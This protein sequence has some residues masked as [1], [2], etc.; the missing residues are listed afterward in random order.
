MK[1]KGRILMGSI[2]PNDGDENKQLTPDEVLKYIGADAL[3]LI[4]AN[5]RNRWLLKPNKDA[6]YY[7]KTTL[8]KYSSDM[9]NNGQ[10]IRNEVRSFPNDIGHGY[11]GM[12]VDGGEF[13]FVH[14]HEKWDHAMSEQSKAAIA[15]RVEIGVT[16]VRPDVAGYGLEGDEVVEHSHNREATIIAD[17]Y[18]GRLYALTNDEA[19]YVNN[20]KRSSDEK[21]PL[22]AIARM[23][24]VPTRITDLEND[25]DFVADWDYHHT[26]N[27]FNHNQRFVL[28]NMDDRTFVYPEISKDA[29]GD[30]VS[31]EY[32]GLSGQVNYNEGDSNT[33][34]TEPDP[35]ND[36]A[37]AAVNSYNRNKSYQNGYLPGVF[38]SYEEL[39]KVDLVRQ[40]RTPLNGSTPNGRRRQN[41]YQFDGDYKHDSYDRNQYDASYEKANL[42]INNMEQSTDGC[43]P[44]PYTSVSQSA[45]LYRTNKLYQ[46][47]YN[48]VNMVWESKNIV[49]NIHTAGS[50]YKVGDML[51]YTFTD[52][53]LLYIVDSIDDNGAI[54]TGHY[55]PVYET[56]ILEQDPSTSGIA[57]P[58]V[59]YV[60]SGRNATFIIQTKATIM[61]TTTQIKNNLYAYVDVVPT[62]RSD[63]TSEWSDNK[64][65]EL[66]SE[67]VARSTAPAP[68]YTG[69]NYGRGGPEPTHDNPDTMLYEHSGNATAG[70]RIHLFHYVVDTS[71]ESFVEDN[72][73]KVYTGKWVDCGPLSS[74]RVSDI[75]AMYLSNADTN[76][77]NNY[78]K[79]AMDIM[80]DQ[81]FRQPDQVITGDDT[82][83]SEMLLTVAQNDPPADKRFYRKRY[84]QS[85]NQIINED[86]TD[87]ICWLNAASGVAFFFNGAGVK[88]D[89]TYGYSNQPANVWLPIVG[90]IGK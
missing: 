90:T 54:L 78:Y 74:N 22:R 71:G 8:I 84:L 14:N 59:D 32:R 46:W 80:I 28:D 21:I 79:F 31:N 15:Q 26:N 85:T 1:M 83:F 18:D 77:F 44:T 70:A 39:L 12:H 17:S 81:T 62:V 48:R 43:E 11:A 34:N 4:L 16:S 29:G 42:P 52:E 20:E 51:R 76:N 41:F 86:I 13:G 69:I 72:G 45:P 57:V 37:G 47:R 64:V 6:D 87:R 75:K 67:V 68:G 89:P 23:G 65:R 49:I 38:R 25:L 9:H 10:N 35:F 56:H 61:T 2:L 82:T 55:Q 3:R 36:R 5:E 66:S 58:F 63:N 24:D 19:H 33:P 27:S 30:Y 50:D 60:S 7:S 40:K 88:N 73:V 53:V